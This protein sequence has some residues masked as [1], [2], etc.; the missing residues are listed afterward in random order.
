VT[1][2]I[3]F[4]DTPVGK[5]GI[6]ERNQK[7]TQLFFANDNTYES[8]S[9]PE[10]SELRVEET[11]LLQKAKMQL[12]EYFNG[13]RKAFDLPLAPEGTPFQ[14]KVWNA[15]LDIPYGETRS[16]KQIA[17]AAGNEKACRAVGMANNRNPISIIIPCHRVI[18][19]TGKLVGYGGGLAIKEYLLELEQ[20]FL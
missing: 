4:Y 16:Y 8:I 15:L 20:R 12:H 18:G 6:A 10:E 11:A 2:Y 7:I 1:E 5:I 9:G 3:F 13:H 14:L 17:A 19:S